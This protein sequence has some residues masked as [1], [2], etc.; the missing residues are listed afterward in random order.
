ML[1]SLIFEIE[2]LICIAAGWDTNQSTNNDHGY[3]L[4]EGP[5]LPYNY[6]ETVNDRWPKVIICY[7]IL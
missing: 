3:N 2:I 7:L 6:C 4:S 5:H 1:L